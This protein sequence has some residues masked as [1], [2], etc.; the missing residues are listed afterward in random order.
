[1]CCGAHDPVISDRRQGLGLDEAEWV[2][3]PL[4]TNRAQPHGPEQRPP[5]EQTNSKGFQLAP[6]VPVPYRVVLMAMV[7]QK[8]PRAPSHVPALGR[9]PGVARQK[10]TV[11]DR[12]WAMGS[13]FGV[14]WN[15][16]EPRRILRRREIG[17]LLPLFIGALADESEDGSREDFNGAGICW[18]CMDDRMTTTRRKRMLAAG[19]TAER[20]RRS[21]RE[22]IDKA[23]KEDAR[24]VQ[25]SPHHVEKDR[26]GRRAEA[27]AK[28]I[29][30][31]QGA[32]GTTT[33]TEKR[34]P[35][36]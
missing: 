22:I 28:A 4:Q 11:P 21:L 36:P 29:A 9:F 24:S 5:D 14:P 2:P 8:C 33:S 15:R 1:M 32:G 25:R 16:R 19:R 13:T 34:W 30:V 26:A 31:R 20:Q 7:V 23:E 6:I 12:R 27:K 35:L 3:L 10:R 17:L 18:V